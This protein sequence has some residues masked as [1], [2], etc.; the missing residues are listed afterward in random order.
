MANKNTIAQELEDIRTSLKELDT[1][2]D[3]VC[4]YLYD[5]GNTNTPGLVQQVRKNTADIA[6]IKEDKRVDKK[7][8]V[9]LG[10]GGG[11]IVMAIYEAVKWIY[12]HLNK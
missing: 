4:G 8:T 5:D 7:I 9:G 11:G 1:K 6:E 3:R 12:I 2:V 10:I